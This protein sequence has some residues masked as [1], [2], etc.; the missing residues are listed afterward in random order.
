MTHTRPAMPCLSESYVVQ[1][2]K[3]QANTDFW[4]VTALDYMSKFDADVVEWYNSL[5]FPLSLRDFRASLCKYLGVTE[6]SA[7][8]S[9]K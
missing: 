2:A 7:R 6:G 8:L 1:S 9:A 3:K 5:A 4:D